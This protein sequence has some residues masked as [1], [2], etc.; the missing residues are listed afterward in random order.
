MKHPSQ[1]RGYLL[2]FFFSLP[3][4][5]IFAPFAGIF[6]WAEINSY[7]A[8]PLKHNFIK[9]SFDEIPM[10]KEV[11]PQAVIFIGPPGSGKGTQAEKLKGYR[12]ISTGDLLREEIKKGSKIGLSCKEII[13]KG[14][15]VPDAL[16]SDLI[17][18]HFSPHILLDGY[19]RTLAQARWLDE[20]VKIS[21]VFFFE[22]NVDKL[23]ERL[24]N[25]RVCPSC[26]GVYNLV[27]KPPIKP[28]TCDQCAT[29][30]MQRADDVE[31]VIRNRMRVYQEET[32]PVIEYYRQKGQLTKLDASQTPDTIADLIHKKI[33]SSH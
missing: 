19:P 22:V 14:E 25:R 5:L 15:M 30:L 12:H 27:S 31:T 29:P 10:K 4:F 2:D 8:E 6:F 7:A 18:T 32:A 11:P 24:T 17:E 28:F 16:I 26:K 13:D 3:L 33:F 23:V 21:Q 1:K 9:H 20:K